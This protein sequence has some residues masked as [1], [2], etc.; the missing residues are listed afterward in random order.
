MSSKSGLISNTYLL[1]IYSLF[2]SYCMPLYGSLLW[3]LG[4][5]AVNIFYV[6]WRKSTFLIFI[7]AHIARYLIIFVM[8]SSTSFKIIYF[9]L[10]FILLNAFKFYIQIYLFC[11]FF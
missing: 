9:G 11:R 3:D 6:A 8:M 10:R 1:T 7:E 4:S 2:K 5:P